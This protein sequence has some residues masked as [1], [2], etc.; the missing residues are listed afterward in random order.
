ML[1]HHKEKWYKLNTDLLK[2]QISNEQKSNFPFFPK[3]PRNP[4]QCERNSAGATAPAES[5]RW[6]QCSLWHSHHHCCH[7]CC[8]HHH[9]CR[10]SLCSGYSQYHQGCCQ[11]IVL[12][13]VKWQTESFCLTC[14]N[15]HYRTSFLH[16]SIILPL[17]EANVLSW[18]ACELGVTCQ[19]LQATHQGRLGQTLKTW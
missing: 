11:N 1:I 3:D 2:W 13:R 19:W 15:F 10:G 8:L 17:D 5:M 14:Q 12:A 18:R 7:S 6:G 9:C 4:R 16:Q